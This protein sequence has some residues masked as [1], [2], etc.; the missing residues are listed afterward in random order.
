[1]SDPLDLVEATVVVEL[2][3]TSGLTVELIDNQAAPTNELVDHDGVIEILS[4]GQCVALEGEADELIE[5]VEAETSEIEIAESQ[6]R[7]DLVSPPSA[8][9]VGIGTSRCITDKRIIPEC[10][11]FITHELRISKTGELFIEGSDPE[12]SGALVL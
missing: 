5:L 11:V 8:A 10:T 6:E 1:M 3:E 12:T 7:L 9:G 2:N 4:L